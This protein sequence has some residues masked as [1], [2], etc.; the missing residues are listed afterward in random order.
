MG[1]P[2][3]YT[4]N[5]VIANFAIDYECFDYELNL[6]SEA[7]EAI[8]A[9]LKLH[10]IIEKAGYH[11]GVQW[12]LVSTHDADALW[13]EARD[14]TADSEKGVYSDEGYY[15]ELDELFTAKHVKHLENGTFSFEHLKEVFRAEETAAVEAL[16]Q[17]AESYG[18]GQVVGKSWTS[19]VDYTWQAAS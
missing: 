11:A 3:F 1:S 17:L 8:N 14:W 13:T 2:N 6:I 5:D 10:K 4:G 18:L 12:Y 9:N 16:E 7:V 15:R 19:S